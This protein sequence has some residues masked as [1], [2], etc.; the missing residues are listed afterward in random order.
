MDEMFRELTYMANCASISFNV[1]NSVDSL[2]VDVR[3][4]DDKLD[5]FLLEA[6]N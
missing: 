5:N 2:G 4:Y 3:G 1:F 6:I